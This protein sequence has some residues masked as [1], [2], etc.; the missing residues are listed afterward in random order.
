MGPK[1]E[2]IL[3]KLDKSSTGK[4]NKSKIVIEKIPKVIDKT[5]VKKHL[6]VKVNVL[7]GSL[8]KLKMQDKTFAKCSNSMVKPKQS[9]NVEQFDQDSFI[10]DDL[11]TIDENDEL[12]SQDA[13]NES[14][15][16]GDFIDNDDFSLGQK[17]YNSV[18]KRDSDQSN[19][20]ATETD[21]NDSAIIK[22]TILENMRLLLNNYNFSFKE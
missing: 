6:N 15:E 19:I 8:S 10:D 1:K 7:N 22:N 4:Q 21:L 3:Q 16:M 5:G 17:D 13:M 12:V 20:G 14:L 9:Y 2:F 18:V 11:L